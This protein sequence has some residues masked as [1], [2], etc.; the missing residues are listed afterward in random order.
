LDSS[1]AAAR[2]TNLIYFDGNGDV[3]GT[4][5]AATFEI[6][7]GIVTPPA[8]YGRDAGDDYALQNDGSNP[9]SWYEQITSTDPLNPTEG[10]YVQF[11]GLTGTGFTASISGV[12]QEQGV[13]ANG[14]QIV[15]EPATCLLLGVGL[16]G[17]RR[18]TRCL[19]NGTG[20][21]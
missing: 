2:Q 8:L 19:E 16:V 21:F 14:F 7:D 17:L 4:T 6:T 11:T 18:R 9:L 1:S 13:A 10:N 12:V 20:R 5:G 3:E 15:P